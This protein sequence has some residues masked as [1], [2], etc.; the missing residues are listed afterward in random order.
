MHINLSNY[1]LRFNLFI[2]V[3]FMSF[4]GFSQNETNNWYFGK[5]AGIDFGNGDVAVLEDGSMITPAGCSSISDDEGNLMFY[6]NGQTVWNR[7]HQIMTNG[8][9][10]SGEIDGIQS[11]IIVPKPNDYSTYYVFYTRENTQTSP[12]Y[13]LTGVY[14]SEIKFDTLNPLGYVTENKDIRIAEVE[15]TS[16]IA[17]I[18]HPESN[19]I[20]VVCITKPDPVF[21]YVVPQ[22]EF[23]F[24]IYNVTS[25]GVD[26]V[27]EKRPINEN[28]GRLGA[29]KISPDSSYIAFADSANQKVYFY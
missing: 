14:Y 13:F 8:E 16:R 10:L 23:I 15:S 17:A 21:G 6:T 2:I 26:I 28:L 24:R 12:I 3:S 11:A 19:T 4:I 20:R 18:H 1:H 27:P 7:N 25:T 9:G 22:G 5:N 29:M